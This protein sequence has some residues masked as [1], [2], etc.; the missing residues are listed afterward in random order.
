MS[1]SRG[2]AALRMHSR[3]GRPQTRQVRGA[4]AAVGYA[5]G[6]DDVYVHQAPEC[7]LLF[8]CHSL[9]LCLVGRG[10]YHIICLE[11]CAQ[12]AQG[13]CEHAPCEGLVEGLHGGFGH[14]GG[15]AGLLL[16]PR[17]DH[18]EHHQGAM[19]PCLHQTRLHIAAP[20]ARCQ[21]LFESHHRELKIKLRDFKWQASLC[22]CNW[23][24][25]RRGAASLFSAL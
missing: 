12:V 14:D 3:A 13:A 6:A 1:W 17:H 16:R 15:R 8:D 18:R 19:R 10:L 21:Q 20:V 4:G 7:V 23:C 11:A 24:S 22:F 5:P 2:C 25:L 9:A